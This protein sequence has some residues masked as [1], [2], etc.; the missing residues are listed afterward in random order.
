MRRYFHLEPFVKLVYPGQS[1]KITFDLGPNLKIA[2]AEY[3]KLPNI[4]LMATPGPTFTYK[5]FNLN[6]LLRFNNC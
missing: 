6:F 5:V 4:I 1:V 2:L 3:S